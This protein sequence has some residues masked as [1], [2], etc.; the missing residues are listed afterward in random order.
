VSGLVIAA[1]VLAPWQLRFAMDA[2]D[3]YRA[4]L[5]Q[6]IDEGE[7]GTLG[8]LAAAGFAYQALST[9]NTRKVRLMSRLSAGLATLMVGQTLLWLAALG[10]N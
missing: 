4:L 7:S 5:S 2:G 8:W 3:L 6:A 10:L 1:V 9:G